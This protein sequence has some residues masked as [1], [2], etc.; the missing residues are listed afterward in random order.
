MPTEYQDCSTGVCYHTHEPGGGAGEGGG[1]GDGP[2][3]AASG[4]TGVVCG[5]CGETC[6]TG[7][8]PVPCPNNYVLLGITVDPYTAGGDEAEITVGGLHFEET[9][10]TSGG[11][12]EIPV[13]AGS[14]SITAKKPGYQA[15][16]RKTPPLGKAP[17]QCGY[18]MYFILERAPP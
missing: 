3:P 2:E 7:P 11:Y 5:K 4:V 16:T 15:Q 10:T 17:Y 1:T 13:D 14:Y 18:L 9:P 8:D 6:P 12:T